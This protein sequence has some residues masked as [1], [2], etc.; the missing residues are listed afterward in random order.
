MFSG[1]EIA[2]A[3]GKSFHLLQLGLFHALSEANTPGIGKVKGIEAYRN[4]PVFRSAISAEKAQ[5]KNTENFTRKVDIVLEGAN[6]EESWWELKSWKAKSK[7]NR[8]PEQT[9]KIWT[10]LQGRED[11]KGNV[12]VHLADG[13]AE[14][15]GE[16]HRQFCLDRI[17]EKNGAR[18]SKKEAGARG[19]PRENESD[20]APLI[21]V[22]NF[23][24]Q[25]HKFSVGTK[26]SPTG[27]KLEEMFVKNP[28]GDV[29]TFKLQRVGDTASKG[30][31]NLGATEQLMEILKQSGFALAEEA[32]N[33]IM[34]IPE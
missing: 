27:S 12:I 22:S 10:F 15:S 25:F 1:Q 34:V 14:K 26:I 20:R 8:A 32:L 3:H 30:R 5:W 21:T 17:A 19:V 31:I 2:T 13:D 33:D 23:N 16:G 24:W 9:T 18:Y 29:K 4:V 7:T 11:T 6:N 28:R